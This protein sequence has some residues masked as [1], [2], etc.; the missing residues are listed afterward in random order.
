MDHCA[1]DAWWA[2]PVLLG[3][4]WTGTEW[5]KG[6]GGCTVAHGRYDLMLPLLSRS[7]GG[8]CLILYHLL[9][10]CTG[11]L[12]SCQPRLHPAKGECNPKSLSS[13]RGVKVNYPKEKGAVKEK[14]R[15]EINNNH[16]YQWSLLCGET[17]SLNIWSAA[18][19]EE[20]V[21]EPPRGEKG[22]IH[23]YYAELSSASFT[24]GNW[25]IHF[26]DLHTINVLIWRNKVLKTC[27][28]LQRNGNR[29]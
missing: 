15:T 16:A 4:R 3:A 22:G 26:C 8:L 21:F 17:F 25:C 9:A 20:T 14:N 5:G 12:C 7:M 10:R 6:G 27:E 2:F 19:K 11:D 1:S 18:H 28:W 29:V 23:G 13:I 24:G